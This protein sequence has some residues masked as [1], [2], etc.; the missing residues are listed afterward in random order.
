VKSNIIRGIGNLLKI[1]KVNDSSSSTLQKLISIINDSILHGNNKVRI[2][3]LFFLFSLSNLQKKKRFNGTHVM[4]QET[5]L[6]I[7]NFQTTF[8]LFMNY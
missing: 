8:H 4:Q 6:K 7:K 2:F 3:S 5:F 1:C